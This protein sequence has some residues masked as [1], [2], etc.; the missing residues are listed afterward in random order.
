M[1]LHRYARCRAVPGRGADLAAL[2]LEVADG[3]RGFDGC[4]MYIINHAQDDPDEVWVTEL[5]ESREAMQSSLRTPSAQAMIP[6]VM[7]LV[8]E[9]GEPVELVPLGGPGLP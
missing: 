4:G 1:A 7:E 3:L 9:W 6:R 5:W 2:L 8:Q